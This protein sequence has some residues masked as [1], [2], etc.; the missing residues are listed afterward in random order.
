MTQKCKKAGLLGTYFCSSFQIAQNFWTK[1]MKFH[2][3][4]M[5][6]AIF[7]KTTTFPGLENEFSNS[8]TFHDRM[9]PGRCQFLSSESSQL[10]KT[11][12]ASKGCRTLIRFLESF[13]IVN[14]LSRL[15]GCFSNRKRWLLRNQMS[16]L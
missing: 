13:V 16:V 6:S 9:N 4:S 12:N 5:T 8:M 14:I 2:D 10:R 3:F 15:K 1:K 11:K 7:R